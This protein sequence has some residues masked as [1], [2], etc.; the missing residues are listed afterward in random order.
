MYVIQF[1]PETRILHLTLEGFWSV[2]IL[3]DFATELRAKSTELQKLYGTY[4]TLSDSTGFAVQSLEVARG[5]EKIQTRGVHANLGPTAIV[6]GSML[7]KLQAERSLKGPRVRV[8]LRLD[9]AQNWLA[10]EQF[11]DS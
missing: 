3:D 10:S 1:D 7:N 4:A 5:F 2:E 9:E 11:K 8:F 6:A